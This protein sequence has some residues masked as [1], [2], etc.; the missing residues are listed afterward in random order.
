FP[1]T[2][3]FRSVQAYQHEGGIRKNIR[4]MR[5]AQPL[6]LVGEAVVIRVLRNR[7]QHRPHGKRQQES[8]H[9]DPLGSVQLAPR[10]EEKLS[11]GSVSN[12]CTRSSTIARS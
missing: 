6:P 10:Q 4:C 12:S 3:L 5:N 8:A 9:A 7:G 2:T 11:H 1:Y